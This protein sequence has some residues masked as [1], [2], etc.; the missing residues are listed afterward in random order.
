VQRDQASVLL[1][2]MAQVAAAI[3]IGDPLDGRTTM[4]PVVNRGQFEKAQ[5]Y[6]RSGIDEGAR[7]VCGGLG[8]PPGI[9]TGF[10][11][12]PTIFADVDPSMTIAVEEIFGPV[13][14]VIPYDSVEDAISIAN[15]SPYGL[16]GYVSGRD[17]ER[18]LAV[19]RQIRAGRVFFNGATASASAPMGGYKQS[20]NGREMG[21]FGLEEY[22]EVKAL[23]GFD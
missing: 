10:F 22:L 9:A 5:F 12:R 8:R 17:R 2:H 18:G 13:L 1:E 11:V 4:G 20:G 16:G 23:V 19:G 14:A 21:T 7:L 3:R 6:I 15:D